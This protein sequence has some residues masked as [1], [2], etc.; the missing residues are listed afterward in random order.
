MRCK[1]T[2]TYIHAR[3][4]ELVS[5]EWQQVNMFR[6]PADVH[7]DLFACLNCSR[8]DDKAR[9]RDDFQTALFIFSK[10]AKIPVIHPKR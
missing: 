9:L 6:S 2:I 7:K 3:N 8:L 10:R 1:I 4:P 5:V